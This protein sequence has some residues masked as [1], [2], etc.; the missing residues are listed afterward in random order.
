MRL[1]AALGFA[2]ITFRNF[3]AGRRATAALALLLLP[4]AIVG[5]VALTSSSVRG[6]FLF[7]GVAFNYSLWFMLYLLTLIYGIALTSGEIEEGT[8]GYLYLGALARWQIVLIQI[9]VTAFVLTVLAG[10][11]VLLTGL[12][13]SLARQ[14]PPE[15]L[16]R[17]AWGCTVVAGIGVLVSLAFYATCGLAFRWPM[18][19]AVLATFFWELMVTIMPVKFAAWT[20]TN[21]LRALMLPLVFDGQQGRWYRYREDAY[22]IPDYGEAAMYLSVLAGLFLVT[23]MVA[24]MNRSIEGKEAR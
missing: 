1:R 8:V 7:H 24:A 11:S 12:A 6:T 5:L 19:A 16:W 9:A 15:D 2:A 18:P 10:G 4:P 17:D 23:A 14:G 22:A 20:V 13:A 21:N 3:W